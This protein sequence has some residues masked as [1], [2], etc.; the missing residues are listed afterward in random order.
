MR[1]STLHGSPFIRLVP[2]FLALAACGGSG[3]GGPNGPNGPDEPASPSISFDPAEAN[4]TTDRSGPTLQSRLRLML[5][6]T[7]TDKVFISGSFTQAAIMSIEVEVLDADRFPL[8]IHHRP[9]KTLY[10]G[11]YTDLVRINACLDQACVRPLDGSPLQIPV[12]FSVTGV[13]PDTGET[14]PPPDPEAPELTVQSRSLLPHDVLDAEYSRTL[15]QIVMVATYPEN[16]LYV[17]DVATGAEKSLALT[18]P[19][20]AVSISPDGLTAAVGHDGLL[21]VVDLSRVVQGNAAEPL[22][23][24]I[25]APVFDMALDGQGRVHFVP[26]GDE[27]ASDSIHT[28]DIAGRT[29]Q[30]STSSIV[31]MRTFLRLRPSGKY[32]F[33]GDPLISPSGIGRWDITG[34]TAVYVN[35]ASFD[36]VYRGACGDVWFDESGSRVISQCGNVFATEGPDNMTLPEAGRLDLSGSGI[37]TENYVITWMDHHDASHE[38][39]LIESNASWCKAPGFGIVCYSRLATYDDTSLSR[40]SVYAFPPVEVDGTLHAQRGQFLF[41]QSDGARKFVLSRLDAMSTPEG[42]YLLNVLD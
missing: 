15:D 28:V 19:P 33:N 10:N 13:D 16:A 4:I 21:T 20:A 36:Q 25:S 3:S 40:L 11:T 31:Y 2:A 7:T 8:V 12:V 30:H 24:N 14:G 5:H 6:G 26:D 17:Y 29:E 35:E 41:H 42:S 9:A 18:R 37:G 39:A 27:D 32:L 34:P 22:L 38:I 23:L 1:R